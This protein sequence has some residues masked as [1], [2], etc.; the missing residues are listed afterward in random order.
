MFRQ[1]YPST[2]P[3][4]QYSIDLSHYFRKMVLIICGMSRLELK[5][6]AAKEFMEVIKLGKKGQVSIS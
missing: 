4:L 6:S 5:S 1:Q 3:N 2:Q